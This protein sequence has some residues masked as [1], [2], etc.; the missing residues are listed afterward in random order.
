M[1]ILRPIF[2]DPAKPFKKSY[3]AVHPENLSEAQ[4]K[5]N[6]GDRVTGEMNCYAGKGVIT[7]DKIPKNN[8]GRLNG[9]YFELEFDKEFD[10]KLALLFNLCSYHVDIYGDKK[11]WSHKNID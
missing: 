6:Q 10:R 2:Y 1:D 5:L 11:Y 3:Y 8:G 9:K 7:D 4:G